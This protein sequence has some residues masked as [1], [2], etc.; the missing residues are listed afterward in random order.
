MTAT[1]CVKKTYPTPGAAL[2]AAL[3]Y[4]SLGPQRAYPCSDCH[5]FHLT[6]RRAVTVPAGKGRAS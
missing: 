3:R 2:R 1:G 6:S 4:S 5:G